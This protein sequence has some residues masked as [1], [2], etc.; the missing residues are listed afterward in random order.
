MKQLVV[1]PIPAI[2]EQNIT[3]MG[4]RY[5]GDWQRGIRADGTPAKN[6]STK[7]HAGK[8]RRIVVENLRTPGFGQA[9]VLCNLTGERRTKKFSGKNVVNLDTFELLVER[10]PFEFVPK[11][12]KPLKITRG[13][14]NGVVPRRDPQPGPVAL[15]IEK[16]AS[17]FDEALEQSKGC[18]WAC[19]AK[20]G[21]LV[22]SPNQPNALP[23]E[24]KYQRGH[25]LKARAEGGMAKHEMPVCQVCQKVQGNGIG[26]P[27][28]EFRMRASVAWENQNLKVIPREIFETA[29]ASL[30]K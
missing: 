14:V 22:Y 20:F 17:E 3:A 7:R 11:I 1:R 23:E 5:V 16:P 19:D 2:T 18:C 29:I 21:D 27:L 8:D 15:G 25:V 26:M 4:G 6:L 30:R 28:A 13:T 10:K 24:L 9:F 12:P